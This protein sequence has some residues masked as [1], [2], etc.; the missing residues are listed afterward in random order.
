MC[1]HGDESQRLPN[2]QSPGTLPSASSSSY[3]S[4]I[5]YHL[6]MNNPQREARKRRILVLKARIQKNVLMIR[7]LLGVILVLDVTALSALSSCYHSESKNVNPLDDV[8][9]IKLSFTVSHLILGFKTFH[10]TSDRLDSFLSWCHCY[11]PLSAVFFIFEGISWIILFQV[12]QKP[13]FFNGLYYLIITI[14]V[15]C[16]LI[17]FFWI[18]NF[19]S[20]IG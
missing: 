18:E 16:E 11:L 17:I 10:L 14:I 20:E 4:L 9:V 6:I 19:F 8:T 2:P 3:Q 12:T 13:F 1:S 5:S 7:F 15:A